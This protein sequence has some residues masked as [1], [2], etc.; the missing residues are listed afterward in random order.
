MTSTPA[1]LYNGSSKKLRRAFALLILPAF[2]PFARVL[3]QDNETCEACH[4]DPEQ[5]VVLY[6]IE[7]SLYVTSGHLEGSPHEDFACIDCHTDLEGNEEWPHQPRLT[8]PDC[9]SCHEDEQAAFIE[10]FFGPLR[11]K[12]YT[13][14]PT[15]A[16]CHGRHKVSWV[17]HPRQVCG[18]CHQDILNDFL[19]SRHWDAEQDQGEV[20]CVSCHSPHFKTEKTQYTPHQWRMHLVESCHQCHEAEVANYTDS[21]HFQEL[22]DGNLKAPICSDCHARHRVLSPRDPNSLV[23]VARLDLT[24]TRCHIGYEASIH[25]LMEG[26][27]PRLATCVACHTGHTTDMTTAH[28]FIFE[29]GLADICL[30]CHEQEL[31][32]EPQEAH[33]GIHQERIV[34]AAAGEAVN[35]GQCHQYHFNTPEHPAFTGIKRA[36]GEC[37][38][39][40]QAAWEQSVHGISVAKGHPEAPTCTTCHGERHIT[41]TEESLYGNRIVALCS[42]CHSNR[43]ITLRFQLN[44]EVVTGY[45][46]TYHGQVY[47]LGYQGSE[48]ATCA[49]CHDN[50][51]VL[52]EDDPRSTVSQQNILNTCGQCHED[53]NINFVSYLQHYSPMEHRENPILMGLDTFMRWLLGITLAVFGTHTLL[54]LIRLLIKRVLEGKTAPQVKSSYRI[55]RFRIGDRM[56]HL[57]LIMSFLTLAT[58]GLPLKYSHTALAN[59]FVTY[60]ISL[61]TAAILHRIAA[62]TLI[63]VFAIHVLSLLYRWLVRRE[64]GL[65]RGPKSLVVRKKDFIDFVR[66]LGYFIGALKSPP[67]FDRWTYW[68]KFDYYAVFWGMIVIG[69]S[70]LTLWFPETFTKVLPGWA[71]NA[72][73]IIHSE[74]ALLATAFIFTVH[75]FN[76]HLRPGAFPMDEVIFTGRVSEEKFAE[77]RPVEKERLIATGEYDKLKLK[78]LPR[79][80]KYIL[81]TSAYFFLTIGFLLLIFIFIGTF[82]GI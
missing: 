39:E 11:A 45:Q 36:C 13:S 21:R 80:T 28:S 70:G 50:H 55:K 17:G 3:A 23:S 62:A 69:F 34:Q 20:T 74:E 26:D 27:D 67:K 54:W 57:G 59:W 24:C 32:A 14:I 30:R 44:P 63:S 49:S 56:L 1:Y 64:K 81:V 35:C 7:L 53:V 8:L 19:A 78:P 18:T 22:A 6:G 65:F 37:H 38:P 12:G 29:T 9:G 61:K 82:G 58:T 73:H 10:G 5:T 33:M 42:S 4:D 60:I 46:G 75:F 31:V 68:E 40:E 2:L 15:C 71:I 51:S 48:F 25:R 79:W 47:Q 16:D 41:R 66:H 72:A 43:E 76:T 52:P 77:E